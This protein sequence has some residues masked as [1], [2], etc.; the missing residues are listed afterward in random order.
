MSR[1]EVLAY[2]G[3]YGEA[4]E[5]ANDLL[6]MDNMS[7]DT[8]YIWGSASATKTQLTRRSPIFSASSDW[9]LTTRRPKIFTTKPVF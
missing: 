8:H 5:I 1:A 6:N 3:R 7:A 2:L 4:Q 9:I